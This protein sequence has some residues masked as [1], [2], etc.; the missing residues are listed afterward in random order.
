MPPRYGLGTGTEA[1]KRS[2]QHRQIKLT[3]EKR[4]NVMGIKVLVLAEAY[5]T[6]YEAND[7][8]DHCSL[9]D[10]ERTWFEPLLV[11]SYS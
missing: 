7:R 11:D 6:N 2:F 4:K 8:N 5:V 1:E 9:L 3:N 10:S